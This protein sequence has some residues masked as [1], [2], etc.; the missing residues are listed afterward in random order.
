MKLKI[1]QDEKLKNNKATNILLKSQ[2]KKQRAESKAI[3]F[4]QILKKKIIQRKA[5]IMQI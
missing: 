1:S 2:E 4:I 3:R 5:L